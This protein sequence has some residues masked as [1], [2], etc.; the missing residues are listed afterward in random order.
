MDAP[1]NAP[2]DATVTNVRHFKFWE[3]IDGMVTNNSLYSGDFNVS[4]VTN[5]LRH[6]K[7]IKADLFLER[8][9]YKWTLIL[10]GGQRILFKPR[11]V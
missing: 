6:A 11:L 8:N 7:L 3:M 9:S 10:Q 5:V 2:N 4:I 1:L